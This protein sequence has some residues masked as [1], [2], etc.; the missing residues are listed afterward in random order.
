MKTI[1]FINTFVAAIKCLFL[2]SCTDVDFIKNEDEIALYQKKLVEM[3]IK[4]DYEIV[5]WNFFYDNKERLTHIVKKDYDFNYKQTSSTIRNVT[6]DTSNITIEDGGESCVY[7]FDGYF[8]RKNAYKEL[9]NDNPYKTS[10]LYNSSNQLHMIIDDYDGS[11]DNIFIWENGKIVRG[12]DGRCEYN[13]SYSKIKCEGWFP[14]F[15]TALFEGHIIGTLNEP[16]YFEFF[17]VH[18]ELIGMKNTNLIDRIYM[19]NSF[20]EDMEEISYILDEHNYI[21]SCT[22]KRVYDYKSSNQRENYMFCS[23]VWE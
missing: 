1:K 3:E 20:G 13:L 9:K 17:C 5:K 11:I 23:F 15:E 14:L 7:T 19:Q 18:P 16:N 10:Y 8:I 21:E 12:E 2:I 6:W 4:D 22:I